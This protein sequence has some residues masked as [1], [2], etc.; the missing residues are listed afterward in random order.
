M[1]VLSKLC[2]GARSAARVNRSAPTS[3]STRA[4]ASGVTFTRDLPRDETDLK[5]QALVDIGELLSKGYRT[6][7]GV[8]PS[9]YPS[10]QTLEQF[11]ATDEILRQE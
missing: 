6:G 8:D 9:R 10:K 2:A 4:F 1:T 7:E 5:Q 3:T 11:L